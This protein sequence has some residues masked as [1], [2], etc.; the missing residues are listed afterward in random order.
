MKTYIDIN[1]EIRRKAKTDS[2]KDLGK[3]LNN[4]VFGKSTEDLMNRQNIKLFTD[5]E[6]CRKFISKP[7]FKS[8][9]IFQPDLC[10]LI[11]NKTIVTWNKP[12]YIGAA[13]LDLSKLVMYRFLYE[14]IKPTYGEKAKLLYSDTDSLLLAIETKNL[15]ADLEKIADE[16]DFSDYPKDHFLYSDSNKKKVLKMK[17]EMNGE[18]IAEYVGLRAKMYSI[19]SPG[20]KK[21][22]KGVTKAIQKNLHHKLQKS[23]QP[24][25]YNQRKN[26]DPQIS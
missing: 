12:T 9:T 6:Q 24:K 21:C 16:F 22:A 13:V 11:M 3:L 19:Y 18:V 4:S 2:L 5:D 20:K 23:A 1:T 14:T 25:S 15:Y 26:A 7:N 17:D 8:F 10:A